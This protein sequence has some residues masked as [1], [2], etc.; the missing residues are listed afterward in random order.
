MV[1]VIVLVMIA[2][3]IAVSIGMSRL[4]ARSATEQVT[5]QQLQAGFVKHLPPDVQVEMNQKQQATV[6]FLAISI[7]ALP[8]IVVGLIVSGNG[9]HALSRDVVSPLRSPAR[10]G[11]SR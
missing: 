10:R 3:F 8:G 6:G 5:I 2:V 9:S 7:I 1:V 4:I 11:S